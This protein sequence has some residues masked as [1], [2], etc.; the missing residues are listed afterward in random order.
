MLVTKSDRELLTKRS[1]A[2]AHHRSAQLRHF[3]E[4]YRCLQRPATMSA[5]GPF[6]FQVVPPTVPS[7]QY[8]VAVASLMVKSVALIAWS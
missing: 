1:Q 6:F 5:P 3:V 4:R 7:M 8:V 2:P